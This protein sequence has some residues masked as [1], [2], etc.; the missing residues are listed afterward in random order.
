MNILNIELNKKEIEM[1]KTALIQ[2]IVQNDVTKNTIHKIEK[3]LG[4]FKPDGS[5]TKRVTH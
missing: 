2:Y 5:E 1:I 4:K 3:I